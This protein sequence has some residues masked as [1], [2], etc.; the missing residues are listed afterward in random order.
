M[1]EDLLN[2][3]ERWKVEALQFRKWTKDSISELILGSTITL[4]RFFPRL[5]VLSLNEEGP[6]SAFWGSSTLSWGFSFRCLLKEEEIIDSQN[7]LMLNCSSPWLLWMLILEICLLK[8]TIGQ[9]LSEVFVQIFGVFFSFGWSFEFFIGKFKCPKKTNI[10]IW[11]LL[12]GN[13]NS[14][15]NLERKTPYLCFLLSIFLIDIRQENLSIISFLAFLFLFLLGQ[16]SH[17]I[18]H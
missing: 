16:D 3:E 14:A 8:W 6:V 12:N 2:L 18:Q 10:L 17:V 11:I 9:I 1:G 5:F 7:L 13:P 4:L 15:E